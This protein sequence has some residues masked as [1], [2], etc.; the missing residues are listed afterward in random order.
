MSSFCIIVS[1]INNKWTSCQ[2]ICHK[3]TLG[4]V[5]IKSWKRYSHAVTCWDTIRNTQEMVFPV[6]L[7][8]SES[9]ALKQDR[10]CIEAFELWH[11]RWLLRRAWIAKKIRQWIIKQINCESLPKEQW[12]GSDCC[13]LEIFVARMVLLRNI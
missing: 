6:T 8:D 5:V 1:T 11:W 3:L 4:T 2:E 10:Q 9:W 7:Y 13:I 12:W